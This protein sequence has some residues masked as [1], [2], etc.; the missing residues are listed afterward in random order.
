MLR[1]LPL[2][3][4]I[5]IS[6]LVLTG[7]D[8]RAAP[9]V[10][11][12]PSSQTF[13]VSGGL[14]YRER[15]A[16]PPDSTVLVELLAAP[17]DAS[18]PTVV[19][20]EQRIELIDRQVPIPFRLTVE[21]SKISSGGRY[22]V[23]STI[24]GA[25]GRVLWITSEEHL[26]DTDTESAN[27]GTLMMNPPSIEA[28]PE[29]AGGMGATYQC[30]DRQVNAVFE[31]H[32]V[33]LSV[34]NEQLLLE[35]TPAASGVKYGAPNDASTYFWTKGE[36]ALLEVRGERYP[37]CEAAAGSAAYAQMFTATGNEPSW[38]LEI[39]PERITLLTNDGLAHVVDLMAPV[40]AL[41]GG[42][43]YTTMDGSA[44]MI[45]VL[46]QV[47]T[48]SMSGM[49][50]PKIV[51]VRF[52]GQELRGCGG[53][54]AEL[55]MGSEWIV[56]ELN[57]VGVTEGSRGGTLHFSLDGRVTGKSFCNS[58]GGSYALTGESL[59]LGQLASTMMAC[60]SSLMEQERTFSD[61]LGNV[62]RFEISGDD[63]LILHTNDSRT[64]KVR[65]SR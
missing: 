31:E 30:G 53:E 56:E 27:L 8:E 10:S 29:A 61:L 12:S 59:T 41:G 15:I 46:A 23:R 40:M 3:G 42:K 47:C 55:L 5:F 2:P 57:G 38:K 54:P 28:S 33:R 13:A 1:Q 24:F 6:L 51:T 20:A 16:L 9:T 48:D 52:E 14:S 43:A 63:T 60:S 37:E 32:R 11:T 44:L 49:P 58:Y 17:V 26:I 39:G 4:L 22:V 21:H 7:C 64:I 50:H 62:R 35:V 36:R 19:L 34:G 45:L 18:F 25:D 65:R